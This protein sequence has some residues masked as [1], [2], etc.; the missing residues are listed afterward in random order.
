MAKVN[1][2]IM[3]STSHLHDSV[4]KAELGVA[5]QVFDNVTAFHA[6]QHMFNANMGRGEQFGVHIHRRPHKDALGMAA[7]FCDQCI[8]LHMSR[9]EIA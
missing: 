7:G 8:H 3:Q 9:D 6:S 2:Q 5:Q 1:A 4:G